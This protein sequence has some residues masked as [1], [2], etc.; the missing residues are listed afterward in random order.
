MCNDNNMAFTPN[1]NLN[2]IRYQ[3][4]DVNDG[5]WNVRLPGRTCREKI[6]YTKINPCRDPE[7]QAGIVI[8]ME[9]NLARNNNNWC[10]C[11]NKETSRVSIREPIVTTESPTVASS[12]ASS[13]VPGP[14]KEC[15]FENIFITELASPAERNAKYIKL[16][17]FECRGKKITQ[18]LFL[19]RYL[20]G[21]Y[22]TSPFVTNLKYTKIRDDG[23]LTVCNSTYYSQF[24]GMYACTKVTTELWSPADLKG[25]EA[26]AI[27]SKNDGAEIIDIF[28]YPG[29][30]SVPSPQY[31]K[32]GRAVCK[33]TVMGPSKYFKPTNWYVFP[34]KCDQQVGYKGM[35]INE[36]KDVQGSICA[37][38]TTV[39]ITKIVDYHHDNEYGRPH[40]YIELYALWKKDRETYLDHD[41]KLVI[42]PRDSK[43]PTWISAINI[44][45]FP[46]NGFLLVCNQAAYRMYAKKCGI[47]DKYLEGP[48]NS[49]GRDTI[50]IVSGD[51]NGYFVVDVYGK[52]GESSGGKN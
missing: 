29:E 43:D 24:Y 31:F 39:L 47:L 41:L 20:A 25:T 15:N 49:A 9:G 48:A 40:R 12:S 50:A 14:E 35:D 51:E 18:D 1:F 19:I 37:P 6:Y 26:V 46:E 2:Y 30:D 28:G 52:I 27:S 22:S 38:E 4:I 17:F 36:W 23:F 13:E 7:F 44:A 32:N 8:Q 34:G 10:K 45:Q 3:G 5:D 11:R 42:F 33:T 21:E 16:F